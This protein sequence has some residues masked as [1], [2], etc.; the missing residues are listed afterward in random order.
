MVELLAQPSSKNCIEIIYYNLLKI[1]WKDCKFYNEI[2]KQ[3]PIPGLKEYEEYDHK[4]ML[5]L[6]T[7]QTLRRLHDQKIYNS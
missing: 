6:L 5:R 4:Q 3:V 1:E 2:T 7:K